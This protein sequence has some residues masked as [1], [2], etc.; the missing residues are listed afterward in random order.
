MYTNTLVTW[1]NALLDAFS[2][3]LGSFALFIPNLLGALVIFV[4]GILLSGWL[5]VIVIKLLS[6]LNLSKLFA[7]TPVAKFLEKA[8]IT[9]KIENVIGEIV[10]ILVALIFF[11]AAVNLLGLT[12]VSRV[13]DSILAYLPN[14]FAAILIL[15]L[16]VLIA[17]VVESL[18]KGSLGTV[19]LKTARLLAKTSSYIVMIFAVLAAFSQLGIAAVFI[20]TLFTGLVAMLAIGL[21]LSLGLGSKDLVQKLLDEWYSNLRKELK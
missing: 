20:N 19:D 14:V 10:R 9:S 13:L 17:G 21:G 15:A 11:V 4:L 16:G 12:T 7:S 5:K 8:E 18:V 1:Q 6:A 2:K 3:M